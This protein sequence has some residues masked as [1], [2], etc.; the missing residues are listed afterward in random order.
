M[1]EVKGMLYLLAW[2]RFDIVNTNQLI[3]SGS[4]LKLSGLW[5]AL[6]GS[7]KLVSCARNVGAAM[8][9]EYTYNR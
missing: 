9:R 6:A 3:P 4:F 2:S 5:A 1:T 7:S 8:S